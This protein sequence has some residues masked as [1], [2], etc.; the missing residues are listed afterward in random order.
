MRTQREISVLS[1]LHRASFALHASL[2]IEHKRGRSLLSTTAKQVLSST[3]RASNIS[4]F[5]E[6][7]DQREKIS[8]QVRALNNFCVP[9]QNHKLEQL[10]EKQYEDRRQRHINALKK[11]EAWVEKT[12]ENLLK[13]EKICIK[14]WDAFIKA[15]EKELISMIDGLNEETLLNKEIEWIQA[16][17]DNVNNHTRRRK[18]EAN[19]LKNGLFGI[20]NEREK[21]VN[22]CLNNLTHELIDIAYILEADINNL[23]LKYKS[24]N[25]QIISEK[26]KYTIEINED[27]IIKTQQFDEEIK[28]KLNQKEELWKIIQHNNALSQFI[29]KVDNKRFVN[30]EERVEIF[31][32]L[33]DKHI[34]MYH[35]RLKFIEKTQKLPIKDLTQ[36]Y[37]NEKIEE[38]NNINDKIQADYDDLIKKALSL[39]KVVASELDELGILLKD[40]LFFI[41]A[42]EKSHL[43]GILD[44][45]CYVLIEKRKTE[46]NDL[47]NK[48]IKC[49]EE[50]DSRSHEVTLNI[51]T[52]IKSVAQTS[53]EQKK[54]N[55]DE[56]KKHTSDLALRGDLLD[57]NVE[58]FELKFNEKVEILKRSITN[59]DLEKALQECMAVLEEI[60]QE[61]RKYT[62][63]ASEMLSLHPYKII[64]SHLMYLTKMLEKFGYLSIERK[65]EAINILRL[66]KA[67]L[68]KLKTPEE[69]KKRPSNVK[70]IVNE[71]KINIDIE[72]VEISGRKWIVMVS[73][74][75]IIKDI[76][77]TEEDKE[78]EIIKKQNEEE[79]KK[80]EERRALEEIQKREEAKKLKTRLSIRPDEIKRE[81]LIP[82]IQIDQA[83]EDI[84]YPIDPEGNQVLLDTLVISQ[85]YI[86]SM[87][88][89]FQENIVSYISEIESSSINT[90]KESDKIVLESIQ[91]E[92][93]EKLRYL[94]PRKGKLEVNEYSTRSIEIKRHHNRWDRYLAEI[95]PRK[96]QHVKEFLQI[97][98]EMS[99]A[100]IK[101]KKDQDSIRAQLPKSTS[102]AE[103][104]GLFRKC[105][106]FE[107]Q[108][109]YKGSEMLERLTQLAEDEI[110]KII[111]SG[112]D[113]ISN[114]QLFENGGNYDTKEVEYYLD[115]TKIISNEVTQEQTKRKDI[116]E[117]LKKKFENE[118][119]DPVK[120]F[121]RDYGNAVELLA[122]KEG[123]GKKYGAPKRSAQEKIRGEMTK[124]E[125]A[126]EGI[127]S[128]LANLIAL[129]EEYKNTLLSKSEPHFASRDP[130]LAISIRKVLISL[131]LSTHKYGMYISAFKEENPPVL[132]SLTWKEDSP[133]IQISI[134]EA[135][136]EASRLELMLEP[137]QELAVAK[138]QGN[139]TGKIAEIEKNAKDE[140]SKLYQGKSL[141]EAVDKYF[142]IMKYYAEEFRTQRCKLLRETA[143]KVFELQSILAEAAIRSLELGTEFIFEQNCEKIDGKFASGYEKEENLRKNHKKLMRPNLG[144]PSC[145]EELEKVNIQEME[146]YERAMS[147]IKESKSGFNSSVKSITDGFRVKLTSN[148]ECLL[149]LFDFMFIYDDF[150]YI[151]GDEAPEIKRSNIKNLY[152][153]KKNSKNIDIADPRG[154]KKI[155]NTLNM[156]NLKLFGESIVSDIPQMQSYKGEG[157]KSVIMQRDKALKE[158]SLMFESKVQEY[159]I[160]FD[161]LLKNEEGWISKWKSSIDILKS[162]N[163]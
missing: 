13:N 117:T 64:N 10:I 50:S 103:F 39:Q 66:R 35:T 77:T 125:K 140:C 5:I 65:E 63:E 43:E 4:T 15:S 114:L 99:E 124:C 129:I 130:S 149:Y 155:W 160:R 81:D 82:I 137:L 21:V 102:I 57:E 92:L 147:L 139:F 90:L 142:R 42:Y 153:K 46:W 86:S 148:S 55:D 113:F 33:R 3:R 132:R 62:D 70:D 40:R 8:G 53:D 161:R 109:F 54:R 61:N 126:Q 47:I 128:I 78:K 141:P 159:F 74:S 6:N 110:A 37:V 7:R 36:A 115:K 104:Q 135:S 44:N 87:L 34:D 2:S 1:P 29:D 145:S 38:L 85:A 23:V 158:F 108:L 69:S 112:E 144:N 67:D 51:L 107:L 105:K 95:T 154:K 123:I 18:E 60:A 127:E 133:S 30:P 73:S 45:E 101:Y 98:K 58:N 88:S 162:K 89:S 93:D 52:F 41:N 116:I 118:R 17:F 32:T 157:Q 111:S 72:E 136:A 56:E 106:D 96:E 19:N 121:E 84:Y 76:M 120:L 83:K 119:N 146:R 151:P 49:L 156:S 150:A 143:V 80:E 9:E 24:D 91:Q 97:T 94:W 71:P 31:K 75:D 20:E 16:A 163:T 100:L 79:K 68:I 11:Y 27:N 48:V 12:N 28:G 14:R 26:K 22:N 152:Q 138:N 122:A 59:N 25:Y 131:R 134:E